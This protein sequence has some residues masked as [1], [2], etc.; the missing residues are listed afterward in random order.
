MF[1]PKILT[2]VSCLFGVPAQRRLDGVWN[3][4]YGLVE[5]FRRCT[6]STDLKTAG[7]WTEGSLQSC[8]NLATGAARNQGLCTGLYINYAAGKGC[9]CAQDHCDDRTPDQNFSIYL[10]SEQRT[11]LAYSLLQDGRHCTQYVNLRVSGLWT[12]GSAHACM[13]LATGPGKPLGCQGNHFQYRASNGDCGCGTDA[14]TEQTQHDF[15]AIYS[16][17]PTSQKFAAAIPQQSL[18]YDGAHCSTF[19]NLRVAKLWTLGGSFE[20][21]AELAT[22][23]AFSQRVCKG[24]FFQ[25]AAG[26]GD[27]GCA[28]DNVCSGKTILSN[29]AIYYRHPPAE[30]L[31]DSGISLQYRVEKMKSICANFF[32]LRVEGLFPIGGDIEQCGLVTVSQAGEKCEGTFFLYSSSNGDCVCST[33][34]CTIKSSAY[35]AWDIFRVLNFQPQPASTSGLGNHRL[36]LFVAL[37]LLWP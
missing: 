9:E 5:N 3:H 1:C 21:C 18:V 14:C 15:W 11:L 27:C 25:Y 22:G 10:A 19:T 6:V 37:P 31:L 28:L 23:P 12:R 17:E 8:V 16:I 2:F 24:G 33:D 29:W 32:N 4:D 30:F 34:N 13:L 35:D 36:L 7:L 26:N 20:A